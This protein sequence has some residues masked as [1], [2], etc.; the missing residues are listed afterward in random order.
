MRLFFATASLAISAWSL[1]Q[2]H[3]SAAPDA[4]LCRR[5]FCRFDQMYSAIDASGMD[6]ANVKALLSQ[7]PS[8][9]LV[10]CTYADLLSAQGQTQA[11]SAAFDRAIVL[12]PGMSPVL[13]RAANF[14]FAQERLVRG[15]EITRRIMGQTDAFDQ[16]LFSYLTRSGVPVSRL[17]GTAVPPLP[18]AAA[19]WSSWLRESGSNADLLDLW[20]WMRKNQLVDRKSATDFAWTF[21]RRKAFATA[22]DTWMDWL[23]S[24]SNG[25]L[26]PQRLANARFEDEPNGSPFDWTSTSTPGAEIRRD[27]GL[28][29]NFSGTTNI[30]FA[31][32]SQFTTVSSGLYRFSAEIAAQNITTDQGPF[33]HIFDPANPGRLSVESSPVKATVTRSWITLDLPVGP[34]TEALKIQIERRPSQKFDD[35]I[36]GMLHVYQVSLL[37]VR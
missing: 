19:A 3:A 10:W 20:S 29:I 26:H 11:A 32:V 27:G 35:K 18:S 28:E 1:V 34:G 14:N 4:W 12:G 2:D 23:G 16:V 24:S 13:M 22:Q 15:F 9:P 8:N 25:Y 5:G 17:A 37:P 31:N 30:D 7:D 33:F 6:L 21:W 36:A